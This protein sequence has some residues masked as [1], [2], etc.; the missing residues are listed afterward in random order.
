MAEGHGGGGK[1]KAEPAGPGAPR[2]APGRVRAGVEVNYIA[3][4][5]T[6][7]R[8][9]WLPSEGV[10]DVR[11]PGPGQNALPLAETSSLGP[12]PKQNG[13]RTVPRLGAGFL[14]LIA[15]PCSHFHPQTS[16]GDD[17]HERLSARIVCPSKPEGCEF[18]Y[19]LDRKMAS[20][21]GAGRGQRGLPLST[22]RGTAGAWPGEA[23][24]LSPVTHHLSPPLRK[25]LLLAPDAPTS[26]WSSSRPGSRLSILRKPA[27]F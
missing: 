10:T 16:R 20:C 4:P 13:L 5:A 6:G 15:L 23:R 25:T 11:L 3:S 18:L 8:R 22:R 14:R 17:D 21:R 24:A 26:S 7:H 27:R 19:P 9:V 12:G 2:P 1:G